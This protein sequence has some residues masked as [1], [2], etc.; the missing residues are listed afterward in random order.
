MRW[1]AFVQYAENNGLRVERRSQYHYQLLGG[2]C[3]VNFYPHKGTAYI[4]GCKRKVECTLRELV[5]LAIAGPKQRTR[6]HREIRWTSVKRRMLRKNAACHWCGCGLTP[7][8]A[9]V[10]H[11]IPLGLGGA[12]Q[13]DNIVLACEPCNKARGCSVGPPPTQPEEA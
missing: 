11:K 13:R 6:S 8:T 2:V 1:K 10:D 7:E 9:T 3:L 12:D 5:P 4:N